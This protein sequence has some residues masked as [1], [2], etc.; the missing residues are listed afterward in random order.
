MRMSRNERE[1][2][3]H[4]LLS[5]SLNRAV[6]TVAELGIADHIVPGVPQTAE[7]LAKVTGTHHRSLYRLLR[8]LASYGLFSETHEGRFDHSALSYLLRSDAEGSLQ[9]AAR[10]AHRLFPAWDG[11][12]HAVQTGETGLKKVFG[13]SLF[14]YLK[15]RPEDA[16][17]FD[18]GMSAIHG[19]ETDAMLDAYAFEN[20][21]ILADIGGGNGSL[22]GAVLKRYPTLRGVLF[23]LDHV[24]QRAQQFLRSSGVMDRCTI[25]AGDFF[26]SI[27]G[28]ADLYLMR[29][30]LHDWSDEQALLILKN[31]RDAMPQDG[32]LLIV[33]CVV[34]AGNDASL[35]KDFDMAMLVFPG[36][37]ERTEREYAEL[38]QRSGF[39]LSGITSTASMISVLEARAQ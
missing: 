22:L 20:V 19:S 11:L 24:A 38:L 15:T 16:A 13:E 18:A 2:L 26:E 6:C 7:Y 4:I 1:T 35:A 33:E 34:P 28:G 37:M 31:C 23:E 30:V 14:D 17:I 27:P 29:H 12:H 9:P 25:A 3:I 32:R 5:A 39:R 21:K 36:G 8:F 10:M